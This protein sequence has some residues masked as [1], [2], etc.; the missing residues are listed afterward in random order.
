M[1]M[2]T[3]AGRADVAAP[4]ATAK[5]GWRMPS[6]AITTVSL[7]VVIGIWQSLGPPTRARSCGRSGR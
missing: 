3:Q 1:T 7:V 5:P 2:T 4:A 6:W